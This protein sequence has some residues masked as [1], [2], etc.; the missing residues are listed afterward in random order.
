MPIK[1]FIVTV[2]EVSQV[3]VL[4]DDTFLASLIKADFLDYIVIGIDVANGLCYEI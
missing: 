3:P 4:Q 1:H 2:K